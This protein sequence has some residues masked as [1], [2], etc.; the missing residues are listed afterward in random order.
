MTWEF[1]DSK[2]HDLNVHGKKSP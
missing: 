1:N 2:P